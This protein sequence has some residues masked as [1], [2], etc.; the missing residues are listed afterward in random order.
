MKAFLA[1][2][3]FLFAVCIIVGAAFVLFPVLVLL[4]FIVRFIISFFLVILAVWALGKFIIF[5]WERYIGKQ[6]VPR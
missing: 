2:L 3:I 4:S 5:V 1:G 6:D